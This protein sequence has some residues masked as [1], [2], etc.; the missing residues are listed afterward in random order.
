MNRGRAHS[1]GGLTLLEA[2]VALVIIGAG[3]GAVMELQGQL[4]R[5][6]QAIERAHARALWR[7]NAVEVAASIERME[8]RTGALA[9][10]DGSRLEWGPAEDAQAPLERPNRVGLRQAGTWRVTLAPI[11]FT[12]TAQGRLVVRQRL[13]AVSA[14]PPPETNGPDTS[15]QPRNSSATR[16]R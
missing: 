12:A 4:V 6:L 7:L 1:R 13:L 10:P 15:F 9:W 14:E 16:S 3:F 11:V 2:V 5:S 8:D